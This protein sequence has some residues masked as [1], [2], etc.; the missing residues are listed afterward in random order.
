[1][2]ASRT[3]LFEIFNFS[4]TQMFKR[5]IFNFSKSVSFYFNVDR[6]TCQQECQQSTLENSI[7]E[8]SSISIYE[9]W[10]MWKLICGLV[11]QNKQVWLAWSSTVNG[12]ENVGYKLTT[13]VLLQAPQCSRKIL[14]MTSVSVHKKAF[15]KSPILCAIIKKYLFANCWVLKNDSFKTTLL[16]LC[17]FGIH[18][19]SRKSMEKIPARNASHVLIN[20]LKCY[21]LISRE[22]V[23]RFIQQRMSLANVILGLKTITFAYQS[24][25]NVSI[26]MNL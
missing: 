15:F 9:N 24:R 7:N 26:C 21:F 12:S 6:K 23:F 1:M 18:C 5:N 17:K 19:S 3:N 14:L 8:F 2:A 4:R 16:E 13:F 22:I 25:V 10:S 20:K 11:R